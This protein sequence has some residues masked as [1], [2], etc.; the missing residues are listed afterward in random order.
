[1]FHFISVT[2]RSCLRRFRFRGHLCRDPS[3]LP[4]VYFRMA[5][6]TGNVMET[7]TVETVTVETVT[8]ETVSGDSD[9]GDRDSGDCEWRQ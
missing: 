7:V 5:N 8:M 1:M 9:S 3:K 2:F 4:E 6:V